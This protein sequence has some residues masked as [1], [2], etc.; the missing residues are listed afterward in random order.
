MPA[1]P[2]R[3]LPEMYEAA[4][5]GELAGMYIFGEDVVQTDPDSGRTREALER[6]EFLVVQELFLSETA[7]L[8]HVVLPG[9]SA[10]E[11]DGTFTNAERRIQR[12]RAALPPIPGAR[13]DWE[14]LC[15]LMAA[16]GYPQP[17]RHPSEV[18]EE[19][20][21]VSPVY[22]GVSHVRL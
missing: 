16:T 1:V 18:M 5:R 12:V 15:Q 22:A 4:R 8:A 7:R 21:R 11:K 13:A 6:L 19:I 14:I 10:L 17:F 9:A 2:G 3:T 20:A